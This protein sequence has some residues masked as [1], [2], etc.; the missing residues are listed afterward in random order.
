MHL[1]FIA[2]L[3][4]V[5]FLSYDQ[6]FHKVMSLSYWTFLRQALKTVF[7]VLQRDKACRRQTHMGAEVESS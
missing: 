6:F 2:M 3:D 5:T 4:D 1:V 7:F